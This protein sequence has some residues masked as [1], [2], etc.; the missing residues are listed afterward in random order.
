MPITFLRGDAPPGSDTAL[1]ERVV[2]R[3]GREWGARA[4][5]S[6]GARR[7]VLEHP[8]PGNV[9]ELRNCIERATIPADGRRV[10][11]EQLHI[12]APIGGHLWGTYRFVRAMPRSCQRETEK[13]EEEAIRPRS[14]Q[15]EGDRPPL[16]PRPSD[17]DQ[18][19]DIGTA[20]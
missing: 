9:R 10:R 20:G 8:W 16:R 17:W 6:R 15:T 13:I 14:E 7:S 1:A 12:A 2:E 4:C 18:R 3:Y 19:F 11:P 5:A